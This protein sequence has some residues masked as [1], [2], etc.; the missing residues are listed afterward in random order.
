MFGPVIWRQ[1]LDL[2]T[3]TANNGRFYVVMGSVSG[4]LPGFQ[5]GGRTLLLN[6]DVYFRSLI[7][8]P[9][10]VITGQVGTLD[11]NGRA[12][13]RVN[14]PAG[15]PAAFVGTRMYHAHG[16]VNG[17]GTTIY[18]TCGPVPLNLVR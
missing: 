16:I 2:D 5:I 7:H 17:A 8:A 12:K 3:G 1:T 15:L 13:A 4:T 18:G 10:T 9:N 6:P 14:I 11:V